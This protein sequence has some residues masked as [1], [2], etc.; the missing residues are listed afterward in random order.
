MSYGTGIGMIPAA[1][2]S[3]NAAELLSKTL[4]ENPGTKF[5]FKQ[6]CETL[7]D[8]PSHNVVGEIKGSEKPDEIIVVGGHLD[9]WDLAQGAHDDGTGI[10]QS[11]E[12]LRIFRSLG[13][14]PKHTLRVVFF[15]N[16]E[17][18]VKGGQKY[19]ELAKQNNEKHLLAMESDEGGFTP[20]GFGIQGSNEKQLAHIQKFQKILTPY[21]LTDIDRGSGG[22]D[23]GPLAPQGVVLVGFK[24]DTQRYFEYHHTPI[25][26]FDKVNQRELEMG[27]AS[28]A[29]LIYLL[30]KDMF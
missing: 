28:M 22:V 11:L 26:T 25:D 27:A 3:T 29:A 24:P 21:G 7:P 14:R 17:N 4:K 23:I 18:G 19:A 10:V 2:I 15:M 30:D 16:E 9:S 6:N 5:F 13:I 12:V 1:A 20:R 8:V